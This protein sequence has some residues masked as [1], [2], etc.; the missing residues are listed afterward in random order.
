MFRLVLNLGAE[1]IQTPNETSMAG[2][3][4][5]ASQSQMNSKRAFNACKAA[6]DA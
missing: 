3:F 2:S 1:E 4:T 5:G 6:A